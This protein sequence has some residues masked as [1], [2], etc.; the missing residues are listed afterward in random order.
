MLTSGAETWAHA[1]AH[2]TIPAAAAGIRLVRS[3][4]GKPQKKRKRI[5]NGKIIENLEINTFKEKLINN[6]VR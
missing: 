5:I 2:V 3:T 6:S 1:K 4:E